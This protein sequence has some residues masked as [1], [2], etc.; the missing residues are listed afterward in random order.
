MLASILG[1]GP[2]ELIVIVLLIVILFGAKRIPALARS[3]GSSVNEFK[4]GLKAVAEDSPTEGKEAKEAKN[5][6]PEPKK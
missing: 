5:E 6:E 1:L 4:K 3:L 2:T